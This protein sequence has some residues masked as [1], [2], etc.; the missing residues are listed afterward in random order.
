MFVE[1]VAN[2]AFGWTRKDI[3]GMVEKTAHE[4]Q[5]LIKEKISDGWFR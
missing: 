2:I 5:V 3:K 1:V 4:K